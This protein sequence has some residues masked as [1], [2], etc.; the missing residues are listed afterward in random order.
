MLGETVK[1]TIFL[2][3]IPYANS[4]FLSAKTILSTSE[5]DEMK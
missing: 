2:F 5:A 4:I 1:L 3:K